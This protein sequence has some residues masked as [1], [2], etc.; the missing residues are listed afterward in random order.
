MSTIAFTYR[1]R[2][3]LVSLALHGHGSVVCADLQRSHAEQKRPPFIAGA[4][5]LFFLKSGGKVTD[6][7]LQYGQEKRG[8][9]SPTSVT[10]DWTQ[11]GVCNFLIG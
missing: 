11:L 9:T 3:V 2:P 5:D 10:V 4:R 7:G 1:L 8:T 6:N